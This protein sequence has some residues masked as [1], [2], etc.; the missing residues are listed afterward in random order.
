[1]ALPLVPKQWPELQ[2]WCRKLAEAI[3]FMLDK[4]R[5]G[6]TLDANRTFVDTEETGGIEHLWQGTST[7]Y[8][9]LTPDASTLYVTTDGTPHV[10]V[11]S[12]T[13]L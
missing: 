13:I 4:S 6:E 12:T 9:A 8:G 1:M 3:L 10:Y 2:E 5:L 7:E 11:G